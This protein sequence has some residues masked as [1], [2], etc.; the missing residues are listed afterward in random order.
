MNVYQIDFEQDHEL[1]PENLTLFFDLTSNATNHMHS[2][3][4]ENDRI[5]EIHIFNAAAYKMNI[6]YT[7]E[8]TLEDDS[9]KTL[10]DAVYDAASDRLIA[11]IG[12]GHVFMPNLK[13][14]VFTKKV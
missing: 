4:N 5:G 8:A 12:A 1:T 7:M 14:I 11:S 6:T 9:L 2:I 3:I 13:K 10:P